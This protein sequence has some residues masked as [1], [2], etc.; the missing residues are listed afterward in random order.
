LNYDIYII[1]NAMNINNIRIYSNKKL[2]YYE[3]Q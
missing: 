1:K 2:L 3:T